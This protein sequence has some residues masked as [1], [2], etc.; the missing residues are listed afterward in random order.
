VE[1][2]Q[3]LGLALGIEFGVKIIERMDKVKHI[4]ENIISVTREHPLYRFRTVAGAGGSGKRLIV[5]LLQNGHIPGNK[6]TAAFN[7]SI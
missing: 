6:R 4:G 2:C 3:G 1:G 7:Y 5:N